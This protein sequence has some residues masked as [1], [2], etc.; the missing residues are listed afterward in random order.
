M[1]PTGKVLI[2][3][4]ILS[5]RALAIMLDINGLCPEIIRQNLTLPE[6]QFVC[7]RNRIVCTDLGGKNFTIS[8]SSV[9]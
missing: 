7:R 1:E 3:S 6:L 2:N 8:K 5:P 9:C 4:Q